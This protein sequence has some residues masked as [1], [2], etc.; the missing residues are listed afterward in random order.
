MCV[1]E[2]CAVG[3]SGSSYI[4]GF[5]D[6]NYKDNMTKEECINFVVKGYFAFSFEMAFKSYV[7][8]NEL[9]FYVQLFLWPC[10]VMDRAVVLFVLASSMVNH[11]R[12]NEESSPRIN[13]LFKV[14]EMKVSRPEIN[15]ILLRFV[16][17][18]LLSS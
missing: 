15:P 6:S 11:Q 9:L 12:S 16:L 8:L 18:R 13:L 17:I 10:I 5:V 7:S 4:Y 1:R 14:F 3:G 2:K